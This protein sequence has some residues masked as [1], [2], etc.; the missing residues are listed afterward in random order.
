MM[1]TPL[2]PGLSLLDGR[3]AVSWW[4][5]LRATWERFVTEERF[6]EDG[7]IRPFILDR[8][9]AARD[10]G[11]DPLLSAVPMTSEAEEIERIL[12]EDAFAQQTSNRSFCRWR[13]QSNISSVVRRSR[14]D[15]I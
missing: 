3:E 12:S 8:W 9:K 5:Q 7:L 4:K 1:L 14:S 13:T 11:I 2:E 6:P 15:C 10:R